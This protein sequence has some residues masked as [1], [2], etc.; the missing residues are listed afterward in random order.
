L[1]D[2]PIG[3][4][5]APTGDRTGEAVWIP[6]ERTLVTIDADRAA[7]LAGATGY[8]RPEDVE[9]ATSTGNNRMAI[10]KERRH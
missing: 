6:L 5:V 9:M 4:I 8:A 7:T 2:S 1:S 3:E 10:T